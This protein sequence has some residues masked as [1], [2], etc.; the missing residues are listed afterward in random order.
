MNRFYCEELESG[1]AMVILLLRQRNIDVHSLKLAV[2]AAFGLSGVIELRAS[3]FP[4][5]SI[6]G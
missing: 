1:D 2:T 3:L 4:M 5:M 6:F